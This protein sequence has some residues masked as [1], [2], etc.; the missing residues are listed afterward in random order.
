MT[1]D[2]G[3]P[4]AGAR[5][6]RAGPQDGRALADLHARTLETAWSEADL[7]AL[8]AAG[9]G[10]AW[11][12]V[13]EGEDAPA[14]FVLMRIVADEAE[15]LSLGVA[16]EARRR[17]FARALLEAS[18]AD[19]RRLDVKTVHLEVAADN[20]A[21]LALYGGQGFR[22]VGRRRGYYV[23]GAAPPA[24]ALSLALAITR[25]CNRAEPEAETA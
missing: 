16:S 8:L 15:I 2:P 24:D 6:R 14:G 20:G 23:R 7:G 3:V 10:H 1:S 11:L 22:E 19:A 4:V 21:A 25:A 17:G 12:L 9:H 13:P 18:C 5:L